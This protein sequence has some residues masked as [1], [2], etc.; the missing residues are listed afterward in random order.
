MIIKSIR[1]YQS[2]DLEGVAASFFTIVPVSG[3]PAVTLEIHDT[4]PGVLVKS[5]KESV[6][7]PFTN[8]SGIYLWGD[9]DNKRVEINKKNSGN[10]LNPPRAHEIKKGRV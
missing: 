10:S 6:V 5:A 3:R 4:I 1:V 7:V 9:E 8:I 2:V